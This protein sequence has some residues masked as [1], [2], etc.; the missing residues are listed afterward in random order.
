LGELQARFEALKRKLQAEG[1]FDE[2]LK[3]PL[4]WFPMTIGIVTSPTGAALQDMVNVLSRRAPWITAALYPVQVQGK[5]AEAGIAR[6]IRQL[7]EPEKHGLP[8]CDVL[9]IG[10]GGGS[11]EDLW[12]FNEEVVARAVAACPIPVV[13]AVGHEIDFAISD[14]VADVRAP[15]P[16]A[17]AELIV[18]DRAELQQRLAGIAEALKRPV[19][20]SF[21]HGLQVLRYARRGMLARDAERVLRDPMRRVDELRAGLRQVVR[22][23]YRAAVTSVKEGRAA[24]RAHHP[25]V[26]VAQRHAGLQ[27]YRAR[28]AETAEH[29]LQQLESRVERSRKLLK[30]LGPESA[31]ERGFSIT[32][33]AQ[34]R[35][36]T[37]PG[38]V[39]PGERLATRVKGGT[40]ASEVIKE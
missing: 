19:R 37:D 30:A 34:G 36:V 26:I 20:E 17:A 14:F 38:E 8:R 31:F 40:I 9:V 35:L 22:E 3:Q 23:R 16:S 15:T 4:P 21:R 6:A 24:W 25:A 28:F 7:G 13:S 32:L 5:G 27:Q 12:N 29:R 11:L 2:S 18:P 33:T 10:R 1:L 39:Q